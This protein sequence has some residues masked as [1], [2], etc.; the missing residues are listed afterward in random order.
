MKFPLADNECAF[1]FTQWQLKPEEKWHFAN[2]VMKQAKSVVCN[3]KA[4]LQKNK[5]IQRSDLQQ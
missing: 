5:F 2:S 4:A 1:S 3:K